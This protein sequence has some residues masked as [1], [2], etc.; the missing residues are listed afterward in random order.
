MTIY[1]TCNIEGRVAED[2]TPEL[3]QRWGRILGQQVESGAKFAIGGDVRPSTAAFL[4]GL[5][6]GLC[7]GGLDVVHLGVLPTPMIFYAK[8]RLAAAGCAVVTGSHRPTEFNGLKWMI[9]D[10]PPQPEDVQALAEKTR[11]SPR[12]SRRKPTQPRSLDVTFDYV[13]WLQE[14]WMDAPGLARPIV[15]DPMDGCWARRARRYLQAIFPRSLF[16]AIHD[17]PGEGFG[18]RR[19]DCSREEV[20]EEL[21]EAVYRER[22]SL[23]IAFDGDGDRVAFVD[24]QGVALTAEEVTWL[25]LQSLTLELPG[26][27]FIYDLRF[28]DQV[29]QA[30]KELGAEA[31][32]EQSGHAAIHR[33]MLQTDAIFGARTSGHYFFRE[34]AGS[35]DALY[36]ACRLIWHLACSGQELSELRREAPEVCITPEL[37]VPLVHGEHKAVLEGVRT[38][39]SQYPQTELDGLRI[40]FPEGW[41]L[42]SGLGPE[43][44]LSFR[45]EAVDWTA[46]GELVR[47]FCEEL[48]SVGDLLWYRYQ[49]SLG[50]APEGV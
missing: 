34:L 43:S 45:F 24:D 48:P 32:V 36:C 29:A 49:E 23:G 37:R 19:P 21:A 9:G 5:A 38:A 1:R 12:K 46:L 13:A 25:L 8:R 31:L 47:G 14:R 30:A 17:T 2:L 40:A 22:A 18:G 7:A 33:R 27:R 26:D 16:Q 28:S 4:E 44:A 6:Q 42:V 15:L 50:T 3:Y 10:H 39:W 11:Q 20:L 41:A 35:D